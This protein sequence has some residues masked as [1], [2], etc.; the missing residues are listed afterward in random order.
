MCIR[1][2]R[3][4]LGVVGSFMT[5]ARLVSHPAIANSSLEQAIKKRRRDTGSQRAGEATPLAPNEAYEQM[6]AAR[7]NPYLMCL[8]RTLSVAAILLFCLGNYWAYTTSRDACDANLYNA[9]LW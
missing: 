9:S 6:I 1:R 2:A 3:H 4:V 7:P 5:S 8:I